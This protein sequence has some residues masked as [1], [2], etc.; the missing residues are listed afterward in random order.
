MAGSESIQISK[1]RW[2][3]AELTYACPLQCPYCSNPVDFAS[4][5]NELDTEDWLRVLSEARSMGAVQLGFSGGEPLVRQDL[6]VL[7]R[8]AR[9]LG[10][11]SNLITS[12]YG[13]SEDRIVEL[14]E[15]G[16]DHIQVSI[17]AS[18]RDLNDHIAGTASFDKKCEVA[19]QIKKHG[20]PMV[21][22]I[23]I[24]KQ[25]IHQM[26]S[27]LDMAAELGADYVELANTQYYGWAHLNRDNLLP[28]REEF[29][30]AEAIAQSY[31]EKMKGRMKIYYV[32]PDYYEDRPKACMNGWGTTF[33]TIAPDGMALPCHSARIL[34]GLAC[35]NVR[36]MSV[37]EIWEE[38]D[39]FNKFRGDSWMK[40][41]C[42]SCPEKSRDFGGCRCQAYL[43]TGEATNADPVC[44]L[45]PDH[46][47]VLDAI[48]S[49]A[50]HPQ[51]QK[52]QAVIFRN[53]ENSR[54]FS[55]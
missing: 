21:L 32:V 31:K 38:S 16:L 54:R 42:R 29:R 7:V 43:L 26:E 33:L 24:H 9:E 41:P 49:A 55:S 46:D 34:P 18:S 50:S 40:E 12:A 13:L 44:S 47:K 37:R 25:N 5:G 4:H 35:P 27:I 14:K 23:V 45:S 53:P 8:H 36:Q 1:P 3:L 52:E 10:Y 48:N 28:T 2:L 39:A 20:Y 22:C 17:Q 6:S 11:Y 15:A 51:Q 30:K 19:H